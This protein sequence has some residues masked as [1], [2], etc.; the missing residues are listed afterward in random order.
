[1]HQSIVTTAPNPRGSVGD[2]GENV[3][4]F[5]IIPAVPGECWYFGFRRKLAGITAAHGKTR[6]Q[7]AVVL[8]TVCPRSVW[9]IPGIFRTKSQSPRYSPGVGAMVTNDWCVMLVIDSDSLI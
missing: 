7:M 2:G 6:G 9:L 4:I 1:M 5:C 3:P 8:P